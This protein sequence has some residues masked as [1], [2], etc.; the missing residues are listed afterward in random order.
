MDG[1]IIWLEDE[2][3]GSVSR[4]VGGNPQATS[5]VHSDLGVHQLMSIYKM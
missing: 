4:V 2:R 5:I 3:T 1:A